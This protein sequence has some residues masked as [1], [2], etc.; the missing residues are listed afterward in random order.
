M[1]I[2]KGVCYVETIK[3]G[4][5]APQC[6]TSTNKYPREVSQNEALAVDKHKTWNKILKRNYPIRYP[7]NERDQAQ[8]TT[9]AKTCWN[10]GTR[11]NKARRRLKANRQPPH[12]AHSTT[13][14]RLPRAD[15]YKKMSGGSTLPSHPHSIPIDPRY[16]GRK[17]IGCGATQ[18]QMSSI[19]K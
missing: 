18:Q 2:T 15:C 13:C 8:H 17:R 6:T 11:T 5:S 1:L 14:F 3:D 4:G 9:A 7:H 12:R 10:R 19:S 16:P